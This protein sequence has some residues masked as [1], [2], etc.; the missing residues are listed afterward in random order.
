MDE[1]AGRL[2]TIPSLHVTAYPPEQLTPPAGFVAYPEAVEYDQ[3]YGRGT[4]KMTLPVVIVERLTPARSVRKRLA[5][6]AAGSG[7]RSVKAV[8][9]GGTY[10]QF[11]VIIVQ[12]VDFDPIRIAGVDML[13]AVFSCDIQGSGS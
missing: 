11:H 3:T 9:E 4:D 12:R 10:T 7:A 6:Y 5:D 8:L 1:V 13:A 2:D